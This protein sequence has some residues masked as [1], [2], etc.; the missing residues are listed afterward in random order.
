MFSLRRWP[1]Q[2]AVVRDL[3]A[4][5][6]LHVKHQRWAID[7]RP[8]GAEPDQEER[9]AFSVADS[10]SMR[11]RR[12]VSRETPRTLA[13]DRK[14]ASFWAEFSNFEKSEPPLRWLLTNRKRPKM[15][16][17]NRA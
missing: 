10:G 3:L 7:A 15:S 16:R 6:M 1:R 11:E 8:S 2:V 17:R 13:E 5:V 9:L 12:N 4:G 14:M